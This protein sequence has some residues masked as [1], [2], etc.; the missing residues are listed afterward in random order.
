MRGPKP[1]IRAVG[2]GPK[3]LTDKD[4]G[5]LDA[6]YALVD[7]TS[8]GDPMPPLRW[9]TKSTYRLSGELAQQGHNVSQRTVCD[10]LAQMGF[11]LQS[12]LEDPRRGSP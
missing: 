8:R 12:T 5:L 7:P 1:R 3:R 4:A 11:S 2:G 9:T 10:L 6:L